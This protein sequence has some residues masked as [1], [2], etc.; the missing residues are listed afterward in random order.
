MD[1]PVFIPLPAYQ[2]HPVDEMKRRATELYSDI[3]RRTTGVLRSACAA[4][5][6]LPG[7]EVLQ[8]PHVCALRVTHHGEVAAIRRRY[9]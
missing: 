9:A 4:G 7:S 6:D 5:R 2:G 8:H 3:G 1:T